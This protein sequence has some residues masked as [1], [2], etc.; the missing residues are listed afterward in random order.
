MK[1]LTSNKKHKNIKPFPL[2]ISDV[3]VQN[4]VI[5]IEWLS[6]MVQYQPKQLVSD[7][8]Y[9]KTN[10]FTSPLVPSFL[11]SAS[12]RQSIGVIQGSQ[13]LDPPTQL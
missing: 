11:G 6:L 7:V 8:R 3:Q 2:H 13:F 9:K 4:Q 10:E 12:A 5:Q 1:G